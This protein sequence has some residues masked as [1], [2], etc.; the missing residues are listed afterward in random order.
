M[1]QS[2]P[3]SYS[4]VLGKAQSSDPKPAPP[5][6]RQEK[7][8]HPPQPSNPV[9]TSNQPR[10][11]EQSATDRYRPKAGGDNEARYVLTLQTDRAHH[12]RMTALREKFFPPERNTVRA[13]LTLF[14][15]LPE[16]K[17]DSSVVPLLKEVAAEMGPFKIRVKRPYKMAGGFL[18]N[19]SPK[20]G[21]PPMNKLVDRLRNTWKEEGF[22]SDQDAAK[23]SVHYTLM[24]KVTDKQKVDEA[25]AEFTSTW[26]G[27]EGIVDG[28]EL[29]KY[30]KGRW[31]WAQRFDFTGA[32]YIDMRP[33]H[34]GYERV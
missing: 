10:T 7:P 24:N 26:N 28:L 33:S 8:S 25:Y 2:Q 11:N 12:D 9:Q 22:L 6:H 5:T 17:L 27:D 18:V 29:W 32:P 14:N 20:D 19:L 4:A 31:Y 23:R 30:A 16:S 15:A 21:P 13:H 1:S 34:V 3:L